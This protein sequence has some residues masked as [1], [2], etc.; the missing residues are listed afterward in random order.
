MA[1]TE[2]ERIAILKNE[3]KTA[4]KYFEEKSKVGGFCGCFATM[5]TDEFFD[6]VVGNIVGKWNARDKALKKL[7][8]SDNAI[9][10]MSEMHFEFYCF[11][12]GSKSKKGRDKVWRS[13][14]YESIY[15]FFAEKAIY[16]YSMKK[17]L[18]FDTT[19][20][21]QNVT[22]AYDDKEP[23]FGKPVL[24][25]IFNK[26]FGYESMRF[27]CNGNT[28]TDGAFDSIVF[29]YYKQLNMKQ[30]ALG[31]IGIDESQVGEIEPVSF[32]WYSFT[33]KSLKRFQLGEDGRWR[34]N[35]LEITWLFFSDTQIFTYKY[36]YPL[37]EGNRKE[38]TQ[39]YFYK[40]VTNFTSVSEE[41]D[42]EIEVESDNGAKKEKATKTYDTFKIV[43]PGESFLCSIKNDEEANARIMGMKAK[44]REKKA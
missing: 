23:F 40:D 38:I 30:K 20:E 36:E 41:G 22:I 37:N 29:N 13:N 27:G 34:T 28:I 12:E 17:Y 14:Y 35:V 24:E 32:V 43:V 18:D 16:A 11:K 39:E 6:F 44:L 33:S 1:M 5:I 25:D 31:K 21:E 7:N 10:S 26:Y 3:K 15:L 4:G 19:E 9:G 8:L 2:K 42:I